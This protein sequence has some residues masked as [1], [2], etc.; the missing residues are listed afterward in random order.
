MYPNDN[1]ERAKQSPHSLEAEQAVI[2][3]LLSD[4]QSWELISDRLVAKDFFFENNREIFE[5]MSVLS[6]RSQP[7]DDLIVIEELRQL[8]KL[9][10]AGGVEYIKHLWEEIPSSGSIVHYAEIVRERAILRALIGVAGEI[11]N[12]AY[13]PQGRRTH[14][15]L[16]HAEQRVFAIAN[17]YQKNER[18]GFQ[19]TRQL[20]AQALQYIEMVA[21]LGSTVTGIS[22]GFRDLD[23]KTAGL[24]PGDLVIV[25]GRPSMGKTTFAMN[26]AESVALR[27]NMPVA[28]FSLEM[29]ARSLVMR[30]MS[31]LG[32]IDQ[33]VLRTG[34]LTPRDYNRLQGAT[35]QLHS[36]P[37]FIDDSSMLSPSELRARCRRLAREHGQLGLIL[38]D[39]LQLMQ[40]PSSNENRATQVS[41]ISRSLKL[42]AK[43]LNV[44]VVA[45]SQLSRTVES[46]TDRRPVMSDLRESGAIEQDADVIMFVYRD[47]VYNEKSADKGKAEIIIGKQRNGPIG[48]VKLKFQGQNLRFEDLEPSQMGNDL[49][50][51]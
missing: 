44:P 22:T 20:A 42:L 23:E 16:D 14:E 9:D 46:R 1:P 45:L 8:G 43:E 2:G 48:K 5:A 33:S 21:K 51:D 29:P 28:I 49:D 50:E 6:S 40:L 36:M 39:Y 35:A 41:E 13:F 11:S 15:L 4:N 31:S 7:F 26:L 34:K 47:E 37:M 30:L 3:G 25:A 17:Q 12:S 24:Q 27:A 38:V 10:E 19:S 18:E 32:G